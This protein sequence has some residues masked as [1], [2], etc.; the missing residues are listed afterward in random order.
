MRAFRRLSPSS[1]VSA[2]AGIQPAR[3]RDIPAVPPVPP[4]APSAR[5]RAHT[6]VTVSGVRTSRARGVC[7]ACL[8]GYPEWMGRGGRRGFSGGGAG[9]CVRSLL[10]RTTQV[11]RLTPLVH[12]SVLGHVHAPTRPSRVHGAASYHLH[13]CRAAQ[14]S[15]ANARTHTRNTS[16]SFFLSLSPPWTQSSEESHGNEPRRGL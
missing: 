8:S 7:E 13:T 10:R 16:L 6:E 3:L 1:L 4:C 11:D 12:T 9:R 15:D 5:A 14:P 2:S